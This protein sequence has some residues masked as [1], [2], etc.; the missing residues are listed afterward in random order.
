MK[1]AR[2][3]LDCDQPTSP[4]HSIRLSTKK[5]LLQT[6]H[7]CSHKTDHACASADTVKLLA[8]KP[9][10]TCH[11]PCFHSHS[12]GTCV[13]CA[14]TCWHTGQCDNEHRQTSPASLQATSGGLRPFAP[15][16]GW[17]SDT[18][19]PD[20]CCSGLRSGFCHHQLLVQQT[21]DTGRGSVAS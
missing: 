15:P 9:G 21:A 13:T 20:F 12:R 1:P 4:P 17:L 5:N 3:Q 18:E 14:C 2:K 10:A 8:K 19:C 7:S 6:I 11:L 16:T